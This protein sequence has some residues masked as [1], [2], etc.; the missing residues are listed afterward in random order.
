MLRQRRFVRWRSHGISKRQPREALRWRM[1]FGNRRSVP[2]TNFNVRRAKIELV[3]DG[4][5]EEETL[6]DEKPLPSLCEVFRESGVEC[7]S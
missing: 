2:R 3:G 6:M 1:R 5:S 4:A 7:R